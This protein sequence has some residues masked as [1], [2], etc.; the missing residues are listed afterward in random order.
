MN[1]KILISCH[2]KFKTLNNDIFVPMQVGAALNNKIEGILHDD[3]MP[4][5]ISAK[6]KNTAS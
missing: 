6:I 3:D 5:N 1:I 4:D 2:K